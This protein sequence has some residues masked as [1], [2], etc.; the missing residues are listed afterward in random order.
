M[1]KTMIPISVHLRD[2]L[3]KQCEKEGRTYDSLIR[4]MFIDYT[5]LNRI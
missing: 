1:T 2:Q 3:K 5:M 4:Q